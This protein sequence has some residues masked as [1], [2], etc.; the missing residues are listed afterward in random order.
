MRD[1]QPE[2]IQFELDFEGRQGADYCELPA[3]EDH[4]EACPT[5]GTK[6]TA[7]ILSINEKRE[8]KQRVQDDLLYEGILER[9]KHLRP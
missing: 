5:N 9:I 1:K 3:N 6:Q 8:R 4:A 2:Q 7:T